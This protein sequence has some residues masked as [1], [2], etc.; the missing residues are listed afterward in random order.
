MRYYY[1]VFLAWLSTK[2]TLAQLPVFQ[3]PQPAS[4]GQYGQT[5]LPTDQPSTPSLHGL[6][7]AESERIN[8]QNQALMR[9]LNQPPQ[10]RQ[11][12]I[13]QLPPDVMQDIEELNHKSR[14]E[15]QLRQYKQQTLAAMSHYQLPSQAHQPG[16]TTYYQH[17]QAFEQMLS[18]QKPLSIRRAVYLAESPYL[19]SV[20]ESLSY[21]AY[22]QNIDALADL[23]RWKLREEGFDLSNELAKKRV[24]HRLF[25]D[26]LT[27][28]NPDTKEKI[29]HYPFHYDFVDPWGKHDYRKL[30]VTKLLASG[31]GQCQSMPLLYLILAETLE[32]TA[33][34]AFS[35]EHSYIKWQDQK[36]HW[37]NLEL[38]NG[39]F[40]SNDL[41]SRSGFVKTEAIRQKLYMHPNGKREIMAT[42]LAHLAGCYVQQFDYD[43]FVQRC[44]QTVL[45]V[46]PMNAVGLILWSNYQHTLVNYIG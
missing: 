34:L 16:A 10:D 11:A 29:V 39:H 12:Q 24:I 14:D 26:T 31:S 8:Q 32:A 23:C 43:S 15:Q 33:Y 25:T 9:Q 44:T 46:H 21:Q 5:G 30:F 7:Q 18:G 22:E 36:G 45:Q 19:A 35:P 41:I 3:T 37:Y 1:F 38:T 4:L 42:C 27:V 28:T 6:R 17:L 40:T 13:R 2:G 20:G